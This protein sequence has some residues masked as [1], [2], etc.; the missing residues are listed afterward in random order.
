MRIRCF[1]QLIALAIAMAFTVTSCGNDENEPEQPILSASDFT[2]AQTDFAADTMKG[3]IH[4]PVTVSKPEVSV[5]KSYFTFTEWSCFIDGLETID[6]SA[7]SISGVDEKGD[8]KYVINVSFDFEGHDS[9]NASAQ[10]TYKGTSIG[11]INL[12][13]GNRAEG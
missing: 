2:L 13:C 3:T 10:L 6:P 12:D 7:F 11:T 9:V 4:I 5:D 8:R 1:L